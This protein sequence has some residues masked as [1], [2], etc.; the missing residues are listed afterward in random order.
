M[1]SQVEGCKAACA[2][3]WR[4]VI[5]QRCAASRSSRGGRGAGLLDCWAAGRLGSRVGGCLAPRRSLGQAWA[6]PVGLD[7]RE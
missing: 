1:E 2:T 5:R 3:V 6:A 7:A 4:S